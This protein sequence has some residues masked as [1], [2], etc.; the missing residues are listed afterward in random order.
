MK[1]KAQGL[2]NAAKYIEETFGREALGD[3]VRA[4]SAPVRETYTSATVINWHPA[5]ELCEFVETAEARL[6]IAHKKLIEEIGAAGARSNMQGMLLR[7]AFYWG[8]PDYMMKR[9]T[10]LWRQF[11]DEGE[12]ALLDFDD[13]G[14]HVEVT[15]IRHPRESFCRLLTGWCE[16]VAAALGTENCTAQHVLCR[17]RGDRRCVWR[18]RG[19]VR[20]VADGGGMERQ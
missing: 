4:C 18:V 14:G 7:I 19:I 13:R 11:N 2:L 1:V 17:A 15:G 9:I 5:D 16:A 8:K 10:S 12:M 3:V 6:S 20:N